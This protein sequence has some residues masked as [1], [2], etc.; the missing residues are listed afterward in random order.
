VLQP[1]M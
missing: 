1:I